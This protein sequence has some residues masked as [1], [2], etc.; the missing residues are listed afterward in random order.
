MTNVNSITSGLLCRKEIEKC[1][2]L[3]E[4][5]IYPFNKDDLTEVGYNLTASNFILSLN[6][7]L[8]LPIQRTNYEAYCTVDP[9]DTILIITNESVRVSGKIA[10]RLHSR[11][12]VVSK[13]FTHI[14]TLLYPGWEG[15]LLISLSNPTHRKL[16]LIIGEQE[17]TK[18]YD[19]SIKNKKSEHTN[20]VYKLRGIVT[21]VFERISNSSTFKSNI[22]MGKQ[23]KEAGRFD[24]LS[25][26]IKEWTIDRKMYNFWKFRERK[27]KLHIRG[28]IEEI[29]RINFKKESN[30][31]FTIES[32]E[33]S[34]KTFT[35]TLNHNLELAKSESNKIFETKRFY[36]NFIMLIKLGVVSSIFVGG[37][38]YI[39]KTGF[40]D[41]EE[42]FL[43]LIPSVLIVLISFL[44]P[45]WKW[46]FKKEE[47][48]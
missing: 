10:G 1:V 29:S 25:E 46:V 17:N 47:S 19:D 22:E 41:S 14:S 48:I 6:K 8:F 20:D 23:R 12:S 37:Y 39:K 30:N 21:L 44:T 32:F 28:F 4:I 31:V 13:G 2:E 16:K 26:L 9:H 24:I 40:F 15:P 45:L 42:W 18:D 34:Y 5:A 43:P 7:K 36:D 38:Y 27:R 35:H 3:Q 11:V 33:E